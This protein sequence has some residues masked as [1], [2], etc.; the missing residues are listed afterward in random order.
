MKYY[1]IAGEASGDLHASNLMKS[2][3]ELD[4]KAEFRIWGGELMEA[5]GGHLV[6]HYKDTAFMGAW[7]VLMNLNTIR[8]NFDLCQKDLLAYNPDVLILV[9]YA[10]FNL[11]MAKFAHEKGLKVFYYI[12]PKLW[13]WNRKRVKKVKAHVD[14]SFVILPFEADFFSRY[15]VRADYSGNPVLDAIHNRKNKDESFEVFV[16][17]N[18]LD[19]RPKVAL[20]AG[21][22]KSEIKYVLPDML[23]MVNKFPNYQFVIA[24]A[25]SFAMNDYEPYIKGLDVAVV[26][27]ETYELLQQARASLVT[28]GTAT[29]ETALLN[30]PQVVCYKMWGGAFS[31]FIAKKLLIKVPYISL[32]NLILEK[33]AVKELFQKSFSLELLEAEL[34]GLLSEGKRRDEMMADY[35]ELHHRMGGPGSSYKTAQL[36]LKALKED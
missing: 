8:K 4:D 35:R 15:G 10:G 14:R 22:R 9:D 5:Q 32:V 26:F 12:T 16:K 27:N 3:K 13:A 33:E 11:R 28:S 23:R 31:D 19:S 30:C 36:I 29:L 25:P 6:K 17:R 2:L 1:L 7:D 18:N 34:A 20:L 24:G 21:S